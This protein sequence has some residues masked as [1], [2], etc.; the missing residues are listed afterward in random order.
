MNETRFDS[1]GLKTGFRIGIYASPADLDK[2][3]GRPGATLDFANSALVAWGA[4]A[5]ARRAMVDQ[6]ES[7]TKIIRKFRLYDNKAKTA[8]LKSYSGEGAETESE[9]VNRVRAYLMLTAKP[10]KMTTEEYALAQAAQK[11]FKITATDIAARQE[12]VESALQHFADTLQVPTGENDPEGKPITKPTGIFNVNAAEAERSQRVEALAQKYLNAAATILEQENK[13]GGR[14][15]HWMGVFEKE[16][17]AHAPF[18]TPAKGTD[19]EKLAAS[20]TNK[21]NLALAIKARE[22]AKQ[23]AEEAKRAAEYQ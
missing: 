18:N 8:K 7:T 1:L 22:L 4:G 6:L 11:H 13:V 15:K 20:E 16:Q 5:Q 12:Q 17:I 19:E 10:D 2:A 9:Y 3:A 23:R 14:V 21:T